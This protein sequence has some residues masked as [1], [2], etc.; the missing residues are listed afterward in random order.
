MDPEANLKETREL[1]K[2]IYKNYEDPDSN[3]VDQD[4]AARLVELVEAMDGWLSK[5]GFL[6]KDWQR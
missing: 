3:G 4:D 2:K 6:P 5:K 1:C